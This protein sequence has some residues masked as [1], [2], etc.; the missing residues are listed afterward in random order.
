MLSIITSFF[1]YFISL[2][3]Y[4]IKKCEE[5]ELYGRI[6]AS[7]ALALSTCGLIGLLLVKFSIAKFPIFVITGLSV[8]IISIFRSNAITSLKI[9]TKELLKLTGTSI[10]NKS[11][12]PLIIL[13]WLCIVSFGP[14]NHPD[15]IRYLVG[16]PYTF[17]KN[18]L[19]TS[20]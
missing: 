15:A 2:S 14:I 20:D 7:L 13:V 4:E 1:F 17:W 8:L 12:W 6:A 11:V 5:N 3:P 19:H 16:Y 10:E 18:N 9:D